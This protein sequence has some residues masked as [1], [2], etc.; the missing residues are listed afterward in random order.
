MSASLLWVD[1]SLPLASRVMAAL[2]SVAA[3]RGP[4][5]VVSVEPTVNNS[6]RPNVNLKLS[7]KCRVTRRL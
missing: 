4:D 1:L 3:N 7:Y 5:A 2:R 6:G